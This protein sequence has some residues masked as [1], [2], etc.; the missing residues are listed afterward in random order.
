M[1]VAHYR[2]RLAREVLR[3]SRRGS[4]EDVDKKRTSLDTNMNAT[5]KIGGG[6][7]R[8]ALQVVGAALDVVDFYFPF[9][10]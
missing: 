3:A 9:S 8:P 10:V 7:A 4:A 1:V 2:A 6:A 5:Y